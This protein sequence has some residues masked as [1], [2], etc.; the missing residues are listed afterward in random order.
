MFIRFSCPFDQNNYFHVN[1]DSI[2]SIEL[3][4][5]NAQFPPLL[6]PAE[7]FS[8]IKGT[9]FT[10]PVLGSPDEI[11]KRVH[12]TQSSSFASARRQQQLRSASNEEE[13]QNTGD[14]E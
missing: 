3:P 1:A 5:A 9:G 8:F 11:A 12:A 10:Y 2:C 6:Y 14:C 4:A 7:P 13:Y